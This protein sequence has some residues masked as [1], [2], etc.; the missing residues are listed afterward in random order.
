MPFVYHLFL[1]QSNIRYK[2]KYPKDEVI[3]KNNNVK[4][5]GKKPKQQLAEIFH[6]KMTRHKIK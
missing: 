1:T 3:S 4:L 6:C 2:L 5:Q